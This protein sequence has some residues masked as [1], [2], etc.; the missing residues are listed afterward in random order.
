MEACA[1]GSTPSNQQSRQS[2][3]C[4]RIFKGEAGGCL[5]WHCL[6]PKIEILVKNL[7][8]LDT[9]KTKCQ[10][11]NVLGKIFMVNNRSALWF[12]F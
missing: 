1:Q 2:N 4:W 3:D 5:V 6:L 12:L 8:L 11:C 10:A 9:I 7:G